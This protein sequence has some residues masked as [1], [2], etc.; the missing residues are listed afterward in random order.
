MSL[1]VKSARAATQG[2]YMGPVQQGGLGGFLKGVVKGAAGF[3]VG[4]SAGAAAAVLP[5]LVSRGGG[6]QRAPLVAP[7]PQQFPVCLLYT[8]DAA[9]E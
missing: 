3:L 6:G 1:A 9:D 2:G 7:P 5:G 4:G 8:S